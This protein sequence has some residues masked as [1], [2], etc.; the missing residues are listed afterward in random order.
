MTLA[1]LPNEL[2]LLRSDTDGVATLTLNRPHSFN[3]LSGELMSALQTEL[4]RLM[5]DEVTRV[6]VL[7]GAGKAFCAGHDLREMRDDPGPEPMEAMFTQ[8]SRI[9]TTLTKIPQP[10]IAK[11]HGAAAAAGCQLVAQCDLAICAEDTK[12]GTSGVNLGLFCSTPMVAVTRNLPRKQAM[13]MLMTGD[14]ID[15]SMAE[16][17]G[18]VNRVVPKSQLDT[19]IDDLAGKIASKSR[20]AVSRGKKL[21]Y[22]QIER[23]LEAA[24]AEATQAIT[25]NMQDNDA[26]A[27]IDAFID[28]QP[29][30]MWEDK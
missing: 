6:V 12:F 25:S 7:A 13:E 26:R 1:P 20:T 28:K 5:T 29:M 19:A 15:A 17:W 22:T 11:V 23:G 21:F 2:V 8:C 16:R 14:L 18:L 24:Y 27:G 10:V 4:D 3:A 9:M 30:P